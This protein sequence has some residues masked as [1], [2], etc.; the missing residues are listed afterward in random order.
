MRVPSHPPPANQPGSPK[1]PKHAQHHTAPMRQN[2]Q[3]KSKARQNLCA[4]WESVSCADTHAP[5]QVL[6]QPLDP[7]QNPPH[8]PPHSLRGPPPQTTGVA[9]LAAGCPHRRQATPPPANQ[10]GSPKRPKHA[11]D[12]MVPMRQNA[13]KTS[14]AR[15][16]HEAKHP[17]NAQNHAAPT[18]QNAQKTSNARLNHGAKRPKNAQNHAA[19]TGQNAQKTSKIRPIHERPHTKPPK[20]RPIPRPSCVQLKKK[21]KKNAQSHDR[22]VFSSKKR[23]ISR[24]T[25]IGRFVKREIGFILDV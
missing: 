13:Q 10:P 15:R 25:K 18:G 2:I 17:K 24:C 19:P 12:H 14:N 8:R 20:K 5:A 1:C 7:P 9:I 3:K 11:Q 16:N 22:V 21:P 6:P 4:L 23:P